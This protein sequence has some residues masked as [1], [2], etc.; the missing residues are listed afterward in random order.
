MELTSE[1]GQ[2]IINEAKKLINENI[3]IVNNQAI[4]IASTDSS[5]IGNFHEGAYRTI[6]HNA[7][8]IL[9]E[10]DVDK[11]KG[12]RPGVNL[13]IAIE[14]DVIG[15]IGIT[16]N[17][18]EITPFAS[19]MK[20]MTELL[21]RENIYIQEMEWHDRAIEAYFFDW[22][23]TEEIT[24]D[25]LNRGKLLG[26]HLTSPLRCS[27][28]EINPDIQNDRIKELIKLLLL[29]VECTAVRWGNNR[30]L[31]LSE[32]KTYKINQLKSGLRAF[33]SYVSSKFDMELSI[34]IGPV[35][36]TYYIK[37]SY[38]K[39]MKALKL[40]NRNV[41]TAYD[42]LLLEV[43]L[44]EVS[45]DVK[46]EFTNRIFSDLVKQPTLFQTLKVLLKND[47]N[48]K[49]TASDLHIHINTLHYRLDRIEQVTGYNPKDTYS[50][51]LFYLG[52]YFLDEHPKST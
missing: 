22:V 36:D 48:L 19:L 15:V 11:M 21:I 28:L 40:G 51:V 32:E 46:K 17:P 4:I 38:Q 3:I 7:T 47:M 35:S 34:G 42:D 1:L 27:I 26:V 12:I 13:P 8:T 37:E 5:R 14:N 10:D 16:G 2:K 52:V 39:A 18:D 25:F 49:Q 33:L 45:T 29:Q 41:I 30:I 24:N 31:I 20:R 44:D 23:Q 6:Q 43:C 50:I 9:T